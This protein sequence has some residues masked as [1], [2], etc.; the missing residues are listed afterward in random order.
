MMIILIDIA[1]VICNELFIYMNFYDGIAGE[2]VY[3]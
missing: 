2:C 1:V 3:F